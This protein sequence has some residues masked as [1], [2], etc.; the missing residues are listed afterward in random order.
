MT[1][2]GSVATCAF[3]RID[4][5][6]GPAAGYGGVHRSECGELQLGERPDPISDSL[7]AAPR[8]PE[9]LPEHS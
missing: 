4:T 3:D 8:I 2:A 7:E 5:M 6:A 1:A 9:A